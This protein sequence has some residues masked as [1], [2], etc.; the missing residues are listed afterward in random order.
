MLIPILQALETAINS[1]ELDA[2]KSVDYQDYLCGILQVILVKVGHKVTTE[3]AP[4]IVALLIMIFQKRNKVT[5]NGLI[6]F[7]GLCN[8]IGER[9]DISSFGNYIIH[10]LNDEDEEC[11][12]LAC[13][14]ISD[15]ANALGV[16]IYE[17]LSDFVPPIIKILKLQKYNRDTKLQAV[18]TIGDL[19]MNAQEGFVPYLQETLAMLISACQLSL[20]VVDEVI[21]FYIQD[22][23]AELAEYLQELKHTLIETFTSIVHGMTK[24]KDKTILIR[25]T[26]KIV[27]YLQAL[28]TGQHVPS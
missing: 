23:D 21:S 15:I 5:E 20:S 1:T 13:G 14:I 27:E 26:E 28:I 11:V 4:K 24:S 18:I 3:E 12:R 10:A 19:A 8:G 7:S 9:V 22:E 2:H 6:A 25:E 16:R 17:Y